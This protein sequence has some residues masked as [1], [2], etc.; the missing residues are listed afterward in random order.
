MVPSPQWPASEPTMPASKL[1]KQGAKH[2]NAHADNRQHGHQECPA[3]YFM[4]Q[5]FGQPLIVWSTWSEQIFG[6]LFS[7]DSKSFV[8]YVDL[9]RFGRCCPAFDFFICKYFLGPPPP[10]PSSY[11]ISGFSSP[12]E[13]SHHINTSTLVERYEYRSVLREELLGEICNTGPV[14]INILPLLFRLHY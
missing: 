5:L 10:L 8:S 6:A 11:A 4:L 7:V 3:P 12:F 14:K 9:E 1:T 2:M 13:L